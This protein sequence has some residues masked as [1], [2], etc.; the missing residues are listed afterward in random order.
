MQETM[1]LERLESLFR[2]P[3]GH[4]LPDLPNFLFRE[5]GRLFDLSVI[6]HRICLVYGKKTTIFINKYICNQSIYLRVY[7]QWS[8]GYCW[9]YT[10]FMVPSTIF[11]CLND[12]LYLV[13]ARSR[14]EL[15]ILIQIRVIGKSLN[16]G[17]YQ[18]NM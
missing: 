18:T 5:L 9:Q 6:F 17:I 3:S 1:Y 12:D 8:T 11:W 13:D 10:I 7:R 2:R 14:A 16:V 15:G 4:S